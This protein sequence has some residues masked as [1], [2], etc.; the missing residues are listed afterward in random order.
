M[1]LKHKILNEPV[2]SK[3]C[4]LGTTYFQRSMFVMHQDVS[5]VS[6]Q[7]SVILHPHD[8]WSRHGANLAR[9]QHHVTEVHRCILRLRLKSSGHI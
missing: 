3:V 1:N 7:L 2:T 4:E 9:E 6:R 8:T 5:T